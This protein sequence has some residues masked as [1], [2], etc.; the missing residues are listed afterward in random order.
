M[1]SRPIPT[2][3]DAPLPGEPGGQAAPQGK[4]VATPFDAPLPGEVA[5]P[6]QS[7]TAQAMQQQGVQN[8]KPGQGLPFGHYGTGGMTTGDITPDQAKGGALTI[9]GVALGAA[10]PSIVGAGAKALTPAVI[11]A[12]QWA[13]RNPQLAKILVE[14]AGGAAAG[15]AF[16]T[17]G[18]WVKK[19]INAGP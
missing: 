5:D 12:G 3:F 19:I 13:A 17:A 10:A 16:G 9:G 1:S 8:Y 15:T 2:P 14:A 4:Q 7:A 6:N 18:K 11:K